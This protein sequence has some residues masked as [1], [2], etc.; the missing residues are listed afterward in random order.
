MRWAF[1]VLG[2]PLREHSRGQ[3]RWDPC[4]HWAYALLFQVRFAMTVFVSWSISKACCKGFYQFGKVSID[5]SQALVSL[6]YVCVC[7]FPVFLHVIS[8]VILD[9]ELYTN[10]LAQCSWGEYSENLLQKAAAGAS[11]TSG[12]VHRSQRT[13]FWLNWNLGSHLQTPMG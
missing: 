7:S 9:L 11:D 12:I 3:G 4:W 6:V 8:G 13:H 1:T 5:K 10:D 2:N